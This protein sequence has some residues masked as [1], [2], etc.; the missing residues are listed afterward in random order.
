M[1]VEIVTAGIIAISGWAGIQP[2]AMSDQ[3]RSD[4]ESI[5]EK[6]KESY[7]RPINSRP[8]PKVISLQEAIEFSQNQ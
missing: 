3:Y 8:A 6:A 1:I 5:L 7:L 4:Y 2:Y